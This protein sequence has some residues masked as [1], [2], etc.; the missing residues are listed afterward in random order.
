MCIRDSVSTVN[1]LGNTHQRVVDEDYRRNLVAGFVSY[2]DETKFRAHEVAEERLAGGAPIVIVLPSQVYGPGDHSA[3]G[4]QL[5][6]A[7]AG[8][9]LYRAVDD[10]SLI[11]I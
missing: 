5:A 1:I 3:F 9:L 11:H 10:L 8:K 4:E 2:Y 7:Y 6:A